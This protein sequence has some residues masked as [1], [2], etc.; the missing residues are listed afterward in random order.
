MSCGGSSQGAISSGTLDKYGLGFKDLQDEFRGLIY[1]SVTG[2]GHT[3]LY[4]DR[5]GYDLLVQAMGGIMSIT[6]EEAGEP[7]KVGISVCDLAAG[8]H[9]VI[10]I[11]AALQH[12]SLTGKGQHVDIG[13]LDVTVSML[14]NQGMNYLSTGK[15]PPRRGNNHPNVVPYQVMRASDGHFFLSVANDV[16]FARFCGVAGRE[17]LLDDERCAT[18]VARVTHRAHVTEV[19][20]DITRTRSASWWLEHLA[21]AKVGCS[22]ILNLKEVF[23][24]PQVRARGMVKEFDHPSCE[25][26]ARGLSETPASYRKRPPLLGEHTDEILADIAGFS[27]DEVAALR[28]KGVV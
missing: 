4:K 7:M 6:G 25:E 11:L 12:K 26:P 17:D 21:A 10:G 1:C 19:C 22:P 20:N 24:D 14:A 8:L 18:V 9:G 2:F 16:T 13:M 3:G 28:R 15:V 23:D 27:P 5:R